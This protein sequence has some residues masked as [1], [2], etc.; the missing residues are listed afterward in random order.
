M[1]IINKLVSHQSTVPFFAAVRA[2]KAGFDVLEVHGAHGYLI[3]SFY[4]PVTNKRTDEYGGSFE[5]TAPSSTYRVVTKTNNFL[6]ESCE[7]VFG[8]GCSSEECMA[9]REASLCEDFVL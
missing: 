7:V 1:N 8:S 9:S 4:S 5:V 6:I 2:N 3:S